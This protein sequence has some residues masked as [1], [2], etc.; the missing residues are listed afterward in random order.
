MNTKNK[1]FITT[2]IYYVTA[3]PHLGSLY[4]T[5]I[6]D[7][8]ARWHKLLGNKTFFLT[9]TDE[10][11]Q[12]IA[13]AAQAAGK[14]P[15]AF[16]DQFIDAYKQLWKEY[17]LDYNYFIRTTDTYHVK[18][19]QDWITRLMEKGDIYKDYYK[20]WYC[21]PCEAFVVEEPATDQVAQGPLCPVCNRVTMFVSE[22]SY[23][24]RLS[25]Y[26]DK[27]LAFYQEHPE[28][29]VPKERANEVISFVKSG[30]NDL[31]ISRTTVK[32][33]IPF[34]GDA[35]H[36]TYV[37]ADA[38]NNYITAVGYGQKE[39]QEEFSYWWPADVHVLGKDI[40]RFHAVYW[41]AFLMASGLALPKQLLVHGWI[42][43]GEQKMSKSLGNIVDPQWLAQ[44]YGVDQI[45]Y[46]LMRQMSISQDT[47]FDIADIEQR[48]TADLANDLG[49]L[50][51]RMLI[52]AEKYKISQVN[53]VPVWSE[54]SYHLQAAC[55]DMIR[56]FQ[57]YMKDFQ[58]HMAL[59]SL[60]KFIS[61]SNAY[62][63]AQEPWKLA[64]T[65]PEK[66]VEVLSAV[67]HSLYATSILLGPVM[68]H[69]TLEILK[70][71]GMTND[72]PANALKHIAEWNK[73]FV[74][75][76]IPTLFEK[77]QPKVMEDSMQQEEIAKKEESNIDINDFSKVKLVV[78]TIE[79]CE[80]V[81]KSNKL[82]KLL[83]NFGDKG[84]RTVLSGVRQH[85]APEQLVGKQGVFVYNLAPRPM[86][87]VESQ[88]MMLFAPNE[89]D[90]LQLISPEHPVPNGTELR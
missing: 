56:E 46:Y 45:R 15:K 75:T 4:S 19:V 72:L 23:F 90:K 38:L 60:W 44:T 20:G 11:G 43:V 48:I 66:F 8:L 21:T 69:K 88:G 73:S 34:P 7:V 37:W 76:Q 77:P 31:S 70:S 39:K 81:P 63:H 42:K 68:P 24:F 41:P 61:Q 3:R 2:P 40:V 6:A 27:L 58:I 5:L 16:V 78:G 26:Q 84:K 59:S 54:A 35:M 79:G 9:G 62:F 25:A 50:V 83:V 86:M 17:D 14:E 57:G 18:A 13:Q 51:N 49:N 47:Q 89:Q 74:L 33:G 22:E 82:Y 30:L 28:F 52:L 65:N 85:F 1:F 36:V 67:C 64:K 10:H 53:P 55:S 12:K 80:E 32:W 87:G 71:V 29:I